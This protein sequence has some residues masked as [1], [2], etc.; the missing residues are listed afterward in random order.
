MA[1]RGTSRASAA[2]A[3]RRGSSSWVSS[4]TSSSTIGAGPRARPVPPH[5]IRFLTAFALGLTCAGPVLAQAPG[6]PDP[7]IERQ[8]GEAARATPASLEAQR[9][10]AEFYY[11]TGRFDEAREW[12]QR[13]LAAK[14]SA[15]LRHLLGDID[16]QA[17]DRRAAA[18]D[19]QLAA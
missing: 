9:A 5:L 1:T 15:E 13:M 17:G 18:V 4:S 14:E 11:R 7:A 2:C 3:T 16:V 19:Y 8:L 6:R 12:V 10:L